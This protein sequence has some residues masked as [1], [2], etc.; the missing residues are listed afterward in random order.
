[1]VGEFLRVERNAHGHALDDLDPV[2][3]RVLRG[4]QR[5]RAAGADTE[6]RDRAVILDRVLPYASAVSV[7]GWP[8]RMLRSCT[9]LKLASTQTWSSGTI[10][11]QR[12]ARRDALADLH[13]CAWR[14]SPKPARAASSRA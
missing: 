6:T 8:M 14:R 2:A 4:Q 1:M 11:H 3:G 7:T 10:D 13:A 9:S 5:K 12:R